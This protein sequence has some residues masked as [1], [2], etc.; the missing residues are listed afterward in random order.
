MELN[1]WLIISSDGDPDYTDAYGP[2]ATESEAQAILK[3][4]PEDDGDI[5]WRTIFIQDLKE[6][7][8]YS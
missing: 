8:N 3:L 5:F 2:I 6:L 4:L 1:M 7:P